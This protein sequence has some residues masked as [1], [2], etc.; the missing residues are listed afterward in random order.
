VR[1]G[2]RERGRERE[3]SQRLQEG[4]LR[5]YRTLAN[6]KLLMLPRVELEW[7]FLGAA[8]EEDNLGLRITVSEPPQSA[9]FK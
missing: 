2:E 8:I 4:P 3:T 7:L 5:I 6:C 1:L 9:A